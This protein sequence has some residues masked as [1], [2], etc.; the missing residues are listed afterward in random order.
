MVAGIFF[1]FGYFLVFTAMLN[2][3]T[4]AY[5]EGSASAQAA[6]SGTRAIMAVVLPFATTSMHDTLG[7][8]WANSLIGFISLALTLIPF[9]FIRYGKLLRLKSKMLSATVRGSTPI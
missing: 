1:G 9:A 2:Y 4:D 6:A 3:L 5:K 7:V 8:H